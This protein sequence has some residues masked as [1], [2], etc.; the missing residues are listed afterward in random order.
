MA[1]QWLG[2][3]ALTAKVEGSILVGELRSCKPCGVV[4]KKKKKKGDPQ[5]STCKVFWLLQ[6]YH[7]L[8]PTSLWT[9]LGKWN[10]KAAVGIIFLKPELSI[11]SFLPPIPRQ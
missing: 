8:Q 2:L 6:K 1:V 5:G 10:I 7:S 4:K 11:F 9:L 3:C